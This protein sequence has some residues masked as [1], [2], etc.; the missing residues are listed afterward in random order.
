MRR[1]RKN[2]LIILRGQCLCLDKA[3]GILTERNFK[4][5]RTDNV[6][7][8]YSLTRIVAICFRLLLFI[9]FLQLF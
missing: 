9:F 6:R 1:R 8:S 5:L 3:P 2:F 4:D 7:K